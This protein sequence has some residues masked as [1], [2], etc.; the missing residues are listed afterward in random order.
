MAKAAAKGT[1]KR[2]IVLANSMKHAPSRCIAGR[3]IIDEEN[4]YSIVK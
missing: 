2:I 3:E 4:T 1:T